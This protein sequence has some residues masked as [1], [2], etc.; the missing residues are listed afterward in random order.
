MG[1][2]KNRNTTAGRYSERKWL[3]NV[4]YTEPLL[5][6]AKSISSSDS[7]SDTPF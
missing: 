6:S 2:L 3:R 7:H 4:Q 1:E 5:T